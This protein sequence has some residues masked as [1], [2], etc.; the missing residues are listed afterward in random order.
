MADIT[1]LSQFLEDVATAIRT[2]REVDYKIKPEN[3]DTEI[4]HISTGTGGD[5]SDATATSDDV[6]FPKTF[7][8]NNKKQEGNIQVET[9]HISGGIDVDKSTQ[10][11][12][13][14]IADVND[15]YGIAVVYVYNQQ[16][17]WW[18]YRWE[19]GNITDVL[20]S[21]SAG[22]YPSGTQLKSVAISKEVNSSG[23][24]NI[25]C[26][27]INTASWSDDMR[28]YLGVFQYDWE[29]NTIIKKATIETSKPGGYSHDFNEDGNMA[30]DPN[31]QARCL[32]SYNNN[33]QQYTQLLVYNDVTNSLARYSHNLGSSPSCY[34]VEWNDDSSYVLVCK[35]GKTHPVTNTVYKINTNHSL[36]LV[37][38]YNNTKPSTIYKHYIIEGNC[39]YDFSSGSKV[40]AMQWDKYPDFTQGTACMWTYL[41]Y[42]FVAAYNYRTL[43]I[44]HIE[45]DLSLTTLTTRT[46]D[47][48][49]SGANSQYGG[50]LLLPASNSVLYFSPA[51]E[52][53][54]GFNILDSTDKAYSIT[55][56]G[57]TF[58]N[59][60]N[61]N[62]TKSDV[63]FGKTYYDKDG[64][65][66]GTMPNN[67]PLNY[68]PSVEEQVIPLGY[69]SGGKI[70][71]VTSDI[72]ENIL[73]ENIKQGVTILGVEGEITPG[74]GDATSDAN[75]QA[76]Y[77]LEGYSMVEDGVLIA[78]TMKNYA[79][80]TMPYTSEEQEIPTGYYDLL[81]VPVAVA[82]DLDGYEDCLNALIEVNN[83]PV[84]PYTELSYIKTTGTQFIN[85]G[86]KCK[87][88]LK[89]QVKFSAQ[90]LS[91][92]KFFGNQTSESD[93]FRFF[94][95]STPRW[96]LDFGSG[97]GGNR[98][99]GGTPALNT[100]YEFEIGNR[101]VKDLVTGTNVISSTTV[102]AFTKT[103][104]F[105]IANTGE[106]LTIYYC[107]IYDGDT[108]IGDFIPA[109]DG[110]GVI[111]MYD[112]V[113]KEFYMN[114]GSGNFV[115]GGVKE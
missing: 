44:Y 81:T 28:G 9:E 13:Y 93:A 38:N 112:K 12:S 54:Y 26:H 111:C 20:Q 75:L 107:K 23:Y 49:I 73:P 77:L 10:N 70:A 4:M 47:L 82:P 99:S 67:G 43:Y 114:N 33:N 96:Y 57:D 25:W 88:T 39:I 15:K 42:L 98:I 87:S 22:I 110:K 41:D 83:G 106:E 62:V 80:K 5:T 66:Q 68:N 19:N 7:Y 84:K 37:L 1:N 32:V 91:G 92:G 24:L 72:D 29:N 3:F 101:Y 85:T 108:L 78:G 14:W 58:I 17:P 104:D 52:Y 115:S 45:Q 102:S 74:A 2:K 48:Y 64:E 46:A 94:A 63:L 89:F 51:K 27:A 109:D 105:L 61:S 8:A 113:T 40:L 59:P 34:N 21:L 95:A 60:V 56:Q 97:E 76:K 55:L 53:I 50:T 31:N 11:N 35:Q 86:I 69:T 6:I 71:P 36:S 103:Y 16:S 65:Q 90:K 18:I 79:T 30:V 100:I